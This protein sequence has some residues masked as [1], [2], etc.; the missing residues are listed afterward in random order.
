MIKSLKTS[1][2]IPNNNEVQIRKKVVVYNRLVFFS[3][4]LDSKKFLSYPI[5][6]P[7]LDKPIAK[8]A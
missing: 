6:N 2:S 5:D 7:K 1:V 8:I 3:D 4:S